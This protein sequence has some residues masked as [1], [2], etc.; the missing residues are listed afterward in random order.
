MIPRLLTVL[1]G[2]YSL[3]T[4]AIVS[5]FALA[6]FG[7]AAIP[8]T[9]GWPRFWGRTSLALGGVRLTV[10]GAENLVPGR[11]VV[12]IANHTSVLD[13]PIIG[14]LGPPNP[15]C[16]VKGE[17]RWLP[18]FN[19]MW[20]SLGQVFVDRG[21]HEQTQASLDRVIA[22]CTRNSYTIILAPEGT[23]GHDG[24]LGK[25]KLG[26]FRLAMATGAPILPVV[27][28]GAGKLMPAGRWWGE[29]GD[30]RVRIMPPIPS[31]GRTDVVAFAADVEGLMR[32]WVAVGAA[33]ACGPVLSN[34][35]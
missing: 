4:F 26:A 21:D 20:W 24:G 29:P 35:V 28:E 19:V 12:L 2:A 25:F 6:T 33:D 30:V 34:E 7:L 8:L 1:V 27:V 32:G 23:R 14:A 16:F 5:V 15:L 9:N 10:M 17:T 31:V 22:A 11:T 18:F 13:M 3:A